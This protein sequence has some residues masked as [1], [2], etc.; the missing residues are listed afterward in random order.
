MMQPERT[1][2]G[3]VWRLENID[4]AGVEAPPMFEDGNFSNYLRS[5]GG[6]QKLS[7]QIYLNDANIVIDGANKRIL[8]ND[9]T[10]NRI[11]IGEV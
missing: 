6:T 8:I 1:N 4:E 9:G 11:V 10:D 5:A 2:T 3:L 7:G